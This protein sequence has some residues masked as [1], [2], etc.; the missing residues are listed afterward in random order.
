M[1]YKHSWCPKSYASTVLLLSGFERG[2]FY[3]DRGAYL[4]NAMRQVP[5]QTFTV[6]GQSAFGSGVLSPD[7]PV[8][9]ALFPVQA[10]FFYPSLFVKI[11]GIIGAALPVHFALQSSLSPVIRCQL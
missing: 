9:L 11:V 1:R 7:R 8:S 3:G 10:T 4:R 5:M 2:F 6:S